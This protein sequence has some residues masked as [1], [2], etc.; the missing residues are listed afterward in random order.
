[1]KKKSVEFIRDYDIISTCFFYDSTIPV[2]ACFFMSQF[3]D[4][5]GIIG[6]IKIHNYGEKKENISYLDC[7]KDYINT[8]KHN[9]NK[10]QYNPELLRVL[11]Y[12]LAEGS[13]MYN[14]RKNI[15]TC[16]ISFVFSSKEESYVNEIKKTIE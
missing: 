10:F 7:N 8:L 15:T 3:A 16:G 5:T 11:G 2:S 1:M 12:Y 4:L 14:R 9:N 13:I 6:W